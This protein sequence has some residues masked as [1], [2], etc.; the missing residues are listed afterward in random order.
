MPRR[1]RRS[2]MGSDREGVAI[3]WKP[4]QVP[5]AEGRPDRL[6]KKFAPAKIRPARVSPL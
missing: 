4:P 1:S 5:A 3:G 6:P 2:T